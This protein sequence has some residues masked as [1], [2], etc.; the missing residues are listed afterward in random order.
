MKLRCLIQLAV[1]LT[2]IAVLNDCYAQAQVQPRVPNTQNPGPP[3]SVTNTILQPTG[4]AS[5]SRPA[6]S[7]GGTP[8]TLHPVPNNAAPGEVNNPNVMQPNGVGGFYQR[9]TNFFY[10]TGTNGFF[11]RGRQ[12]EE[13]Q[14]YPDNESVY[15]RGPDGG[16]YRYELKRRDHYDSSTNNSAAVGT[17]GSSPYHMR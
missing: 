11:R 7:D 2:F 9:G 5:Y 14:Y 8:P 6:T 12:G 10:P 4:P 3:A 15:R 17:N 13:K 1:L 16:Y